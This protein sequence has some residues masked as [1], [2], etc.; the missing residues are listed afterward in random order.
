MKYITGKHTLPLLLVAV[1]MLLTGC[2]NDGGDTPRRKSRMEMQAYTRT[3][4]DAVPSASTR[5]WTPPTGFELYNGNDHIKISLVN[6]D[7]RVNGDFVKNQDGHWYTNFDLPDP[8]TYYLY[9]YLPSVGNL[10][11]AP[12]NSSFANGATMTISGLPTATSSD[13]CVIVGVKK[14]SSPTNDVIGNDDG[15]QMGQFSYILSGETNHVFLLCDH[16]YAAIQLRLKVDE[17]YNALRTIKLK[18]LRVKAYNGSTAFKKK[19]NVSFTL[20]TTTDPIKN[21]AFDPDPDSGDME[22]EPLFESD[23]GIE[24][25]TTYTDYKGSFVPFGITDFTLESTYDVYDKVGNKIRE[26]SKTENKINIFKLFKQVNLKR[27][28]LYTINLT[29]NPTYLYVLSDPDLDNPTI[30]IED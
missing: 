14:G 5:A 26:E 23:E 8:A 7:S 9:G 19:S 28:T 3:Y 20:D 11:L 25:S 10:T 24:L 13:V 6:D 15:I 2:Q 30:E 27:G 1:L 21:I 17:F 22:L 12:V 18:K 29:V 4:A 16:L